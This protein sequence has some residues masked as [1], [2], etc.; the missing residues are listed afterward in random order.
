ML[1]SFYKFEDSRINFKWSSGVILGFVNPIGGFPCPT[2]IFS[3]NFL[4]FGLKTKHMVEKGRN[5]ASK[6][7]GLYAEKIA[8]MEPG[9]QKTVLAAAGIKPYL[10]GHHNNSVFQFGPR[11]TFIRLRER[12]NMEVMNGIQYSST[13]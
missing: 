4:K 1:Q 7:F 13:Y 8:S 9:G 5:K 10:G 2:T 11:N 6:N 12:K 3:F